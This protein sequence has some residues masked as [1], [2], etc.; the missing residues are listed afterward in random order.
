MSEQSEVTKCIEIPDDESS[1]MVH[2][3][4]SGVFMP[5]DAEWISLDGS[6]N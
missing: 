3:W 5:A 1:E 4:S 6:Q 2:R